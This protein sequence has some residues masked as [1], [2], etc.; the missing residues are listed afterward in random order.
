[1]LQKNVKF[2]AKKSW[3]VWIFTILTEWS[4]EEL[5]KTAYKFSLK[6]HH[7]LYR[8]A[9]AACVTER[10]HFYVSFTNFFQDEWS[11][12]FS[13]GFRCCWKLNFYELS[14]LTYCQHL[15]IYLWASHMRASSCESFDKMSSSSYVASTST[16]IIYFSLP[17]SLELYMF[18]CFLLAYTI[19]I[20]KL[21]IFFPY[22]FVSFW[23]A[24]ARQL[25]AIKKRTKA[26]ST[27]SLKFAK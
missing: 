5:N 21:S 18:V 8:V 12:E 22:F 13:W 14:M 3:H 1:M 26:L 7:K 20:K 10:F 15:Y 23:W 9:A 4:R 27:I 19:A 24:V 6:C 2:C 25:I 17:F 16:F 11:C